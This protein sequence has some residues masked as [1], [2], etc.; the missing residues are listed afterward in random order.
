LQQP[1]HVEGPH[2]PEGEHAAKALIKTAESSIRC[3]PTLVASALTRFDRGHE[4]AH[5]ATRP[6]MLSCGVQCA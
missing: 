2:A 4:N 3:I 1:E 5:G 6:H